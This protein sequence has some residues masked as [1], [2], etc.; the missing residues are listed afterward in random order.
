[1]VSKFG[2]DDQGFK[3][4]S[5]EL[6]FSI[7]KKLDPETFN[8]QNWRTIRSSA[9]N[10]STLKSTNFYLGLIEWKGLLLNLRPI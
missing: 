6:N 2:S 9:I 1:M 4:L 5:F 7:L 10:Y 3:F 8:G